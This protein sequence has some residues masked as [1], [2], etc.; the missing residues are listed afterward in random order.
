MQL[1]FGFYGVYPPPF[2]RSFQVTG[3]RSFDIPGKADK[4]ALTCFQSGL[5]RQSF[6]KQGYFF[7]FSMC[8]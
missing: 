3:N 7:L 4:K 2:D 6:R 5:S 1:F 8:F